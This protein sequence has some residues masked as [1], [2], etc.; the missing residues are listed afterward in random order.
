MFKITFSTRFIYL[1]P[2]DKLSCYCW[3]CPVASSSYKI[4]LS[5]VSNS[6][7]QRPNMNRVV[8][9]RAISRSRQFLRRPGSSTYVIIALFPVAHDVSYGP[10]HGLPAKISYHQVAVSMPETTD[11]SHCEVR[12]T[13]SAVTVTEES[14]MPGSVDVD[15]FGDDACIG[16][17]Q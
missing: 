3:A 5:V 16:R 2:F 9:S 1:H 17:S 4:R 10:T 12:S 13:R 6:P 8:F 14:A 7:H 15:L 11:C